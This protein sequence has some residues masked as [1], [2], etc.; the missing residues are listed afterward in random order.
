MH[1]ALC[2]MQAFS[3]NKWKFILMWTEQSENIARNNVIMIKDTNSFQLKLHLSNFCYCH[4]ESRQFLDLIYREKRLHSA[5]FLYDYWL[6]FIKWGEEN[7]VILANIWVLPTWFISELGQDTEPDNSDQACPIDRKLVPCS[8]A[9]KT[10]KKRKCTLP[11]QA[12]SCSGSKGLSQ[13]VLPA[14]SRLSKQ[15]RCCSR[16]RHPWCLSY[17]N[18]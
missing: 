8:H 6:K 13:P 12:L 9:K 18:T 15:S 2:I 1:H 10:K 3:C 7:T 16:D 17:V 11:T 4:L 5:D 14:F